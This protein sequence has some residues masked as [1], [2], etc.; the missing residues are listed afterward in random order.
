MEG[1]SVSNIYSISSSILHRQL[2]IKLYIYKKG[3]TAR[4]SKI[5]FQE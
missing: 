1:I 2:A 4:D 3:V 5:R